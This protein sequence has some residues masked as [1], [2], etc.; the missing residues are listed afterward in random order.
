[1]PKTTLIVAAISEAPKLIFNAC[2]VRSSVAI[3][4][5]S[6]QPNAVER[7]TTPDRGMSTISER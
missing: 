5:N 4:E 1:M 2:S 3:A 7:Q 6:A